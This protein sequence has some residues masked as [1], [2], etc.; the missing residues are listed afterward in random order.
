[1]R[2]ERPFG[3]RMVQLK[4]SGAGAWSR[5]CT[6]RGG[7]LVVCA[8]CGDSGRALHG[9]QVIGGGYMDLGGVVE[10]EVQNETG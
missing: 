2:E 9:G 7:G 1:M 10:K 6:F 3:W 4:R 5:G 8:Q